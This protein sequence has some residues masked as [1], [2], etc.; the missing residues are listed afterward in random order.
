MWGRTENWKLFWD[1]EIE[2]IEM[3]FQKIDNSLISQNEF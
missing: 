2:I 1:W 3:E